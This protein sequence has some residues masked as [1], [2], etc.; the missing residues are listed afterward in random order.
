MLQLAYPAGKE[1]I[2]LGTT[3][4]RVSQAA[5]GPSMTLTNGVAFSHDEVPPVLLDRIAHTTYVDAV[6]C[7]RS[8]SVVCQSVTVVSHAKTAELIEMPFGLRTQ[9]GP[10][11][12]VLDGGTDPPMRRGNFEGGKVRPIVKYRTLC[13]HLCENG[14]IDH[15]AVLTVISEWPKES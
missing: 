3:G 1:G 13:G 6:Y 7:Y 11:N 15:H 4:S 5:R 10:G 8:S 2:C 9:V 12:H 14:C